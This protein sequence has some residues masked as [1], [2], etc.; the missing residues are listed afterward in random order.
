[1]TYW[2]LDVCDC[3]VFMIWFLPLCHL[4][5]VVRTC[6]AQC[7]QRKL[8]MNCLV[9]SDLRKFP[10]PSR[11]AWMKALNCQWNTS[12]KLNVESSFPFQNV[13]CY[14][15]FYASSIWLGMSGNAARKGSI[16]FTG[17][18]A[19]GPTWFLIEPNSY[20]ELAHFHFS[21]TKIWH[22]LFSV[23]MLRCNIES[24]FQV[25]F[26]VPSTYILLG[27]HNMQ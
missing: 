26:A 6:C 10:L 19:R 25:W 15:L 14:D 24:R 9:L 3:S 7:L 2:P 21:Q 11:A 4:F 5:Y 17:E 1:M 13:A 20:V 12:R 22:G 18:T 8:E 23:H 27:P 16:V